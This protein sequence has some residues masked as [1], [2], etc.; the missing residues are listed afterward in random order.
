MIPDFNP[1]DIPLRH[2]LIGPLLAW[3]AKV[4]QDRCF[5]QFED[6]T[7]SFSEAHRQVHA[8]ARGLLARG[9]TTQEHI[10][11]LL[12]NGLEIVLAWFACAVIRAVNVPLN[13]A[14]AGRLLDKPM[15]DT[16][17]RALI[18]GREQ[19]AALAS[20][21]DAVRE[22]LDWV[23]VVGG[24]EG[25]DLP[26]GPSRYIDWKDLLIADGTDITITADF[27]DQQTVFYTSGTTGPA[28]GVQT[29]NAHQ[30]SAACGFVRAV[31]LTRDDILYTPFPLFHG[32][33]ARLGVLPCLIVG[34]K[35][36]IGRKFSA[37]RY[38]QEATACKATVGQSIFSTPG[39]LLEQAPG[40]WDRAH[41]LRAMYNSH[42]HPVFE[43]RFG[44]RLV[45][46]FSMTETG[47]VLYSR[48]PHH[49]PGSA[50]RVHEDWEAALVDEND[51]PVADGQSG[52]L[53]VR[54]KL[55]HIMMQGYLNQP[56]ATV[57]AF[58]NLW[59]HT[60][61][62]MRRDSEGWYFYVD[63]AKERIRRRGEN[64]SSFE[65]EQ[66]ASEHPAIAL[67]AALPL[68]AGPHDD[69][70]RL[71]AVRKPDQTLSEA[72]FC[73]WLDARLPSLLRPRYIEFFSELPVTAT[74]KIEKVKLIRAG[75]SSQSW[76]RTSS[77][78]T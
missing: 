2:R 29:L 68:A 48:W 28:K 74:S 1:Q 35:A 37:S 42:S 46:A 11:I 47:F 61:D 78:A 76:D 12:P 13:P 14:L 22:Q 69:D 64:I 10:A 15:Q 34:A 77:E 71:V 40:P 45:E 59:F 75:L 18:V 63:R 67:C 3:R 9:I 6:H 62:I 32:L 66:I 5:L 23:A 53:V 25:I 26:A 65:I 57:A 27:R 54:P 49:R 38:W 7:L 4:E 30:F 16:R 51:Q 8:L 36:V 44:V 39:I 73:E 70:I 41:S 50:G 60:G 21:S 52:E 43:A 33:A 31:G 19:L 55:P 56:E 58:R 72:E 24:L 17:A 20:L